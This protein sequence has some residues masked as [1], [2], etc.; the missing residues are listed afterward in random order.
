MTKL[1]NNL[2]RLLFCLLAVLL[3]PV[4]VQ[5]LGQIDVEKDASLTIK[6][7]YDGEAIPGADFDIYRVAKVSKSGTFTLV[8]DFKD[9]KVAVND[10]TTRQWD[11]LAETLSG[12]VKLDDLEAY[13]SGTTDRN[14]RLE[15]EDLPTGLYLVIGHRC[16]IGDYTYTAEPFLVS[17]PD[18]TA[19]KSDW[20]Y[21]VTARPKPDRDELEEPA[22]VTRKVLKIWE[23]DGLEEDRPSRITVHLLRDGEVFDTVTLT[24][25]N[26]WRWTWEA[27]P[28]EY[29]WMV[30]E[31]VP[32]GY[33]VR[34]SR[35][36]VT[37]VITNTVEEE[38]PVEIPDDD[39]P[40]GDLDIPDEPVP[41]GP[42]LP[43]TGQLWWPVP[44]LL[45]GG[46]FLIVLGLLRRR[47][48]ED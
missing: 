13:D 31:D 43:Q 24:A 48:S 16:E 30:V 21:T 15:F 38:P 35:E 45:A 36:G 1:K 37:F 27:L 33:T 3:L 23:D 14:G 39:T 32:D 18:Y 20:D 7:T 10:L 28:A 11:R 4:P 6:F 46:L 22:V 25:Q 8:G 5:A 42:R 12:Y 34:T 2:R 41:S 9:Y 29:D 19:D 44:V 26:N 40:T 47:M 17:L